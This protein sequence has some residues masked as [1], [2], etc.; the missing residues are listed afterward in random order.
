MRRCCQLLLLKFSTNG[1]DLMAPTIF[2]LATFG[3]KFLFGPAAG[4][5]MDRT[6]RMRV[7]RTGIALQAVG[8]CAALGVLGLLVLQRDAAPH[9]TLSSEAAI[10]MDDPAST[11][12][13]FP[14]GSRRGLTSAGGVPAILLALMVLCGILESLG[15]LIS[16]VAVKKDWVPSIWA[17]KDPILSWINTAMA[18]IDLLAEIAGPLGGGV[19]LQS[20]GGDAALGFTLIGLANVVTFGLELM[21]LRA[22]YYSNAQLQAPKPVPE[23]AGGESASSE[24][25]HA[26]GGSGDDGCCAGML[27]T[28]SAFLSHPSGI[29]LLVISYSLLYFTVLS[30]HGVVLTAY[31]QTRGLSPPALAAFRAA[32]ALAGVGGM[33]AFGALRERVGLRRLASV[34]LWVLATAVL[35]AALSFAAT[36][37]QDGL[38]AP[39]AAF[40]G[41][42]VLSR[43][44]LYGF[45]VAVLQLQQVHVDET[46]RGSVGSVES[47]LCSMGTASVLVGTLV[48]SAS[49]DPHAFDLLVFASAGFVGSAA[50][51]Y[52]AW[53]LFFHEHEHAH[54]LFEPA[55]ELHTSGGRIPGAQHKHTHQQRRELEESPGRT[56][57]H[58]HFHPPWSHA[59][60]AHLKAVAHGHHGTH[61]SSAEYHHHGHSH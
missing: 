24:G 2:G 22:V 9:G 16:S 39:M 1:S 38:S 12:D 28:W 54:P 40:L 23:R 52:T 7:V 41:L 44:G 20:F 35:V 61:D 33:G 57:K 45:D 42:V 30:P 29:P 18:N 10:R 34:H 59:S 8:V 32:G 48:A 49:G 26:A 37:S 27:G 50:I 43:F 4:R 58:L 31:L 60:N 19:V 15:A 17:P 55:P 46:L 3:F 21:L 13:L 6:D 47:S 11:R 53:V 36:L 25:G 51:V 5:W 56:H 14:A